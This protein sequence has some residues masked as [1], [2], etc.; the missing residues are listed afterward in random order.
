MIAEFVD[1]LAAAGLELTYDQIL[2]VLWLAGNLPKVQW[3][4]LH[5]TN[6]EQL[7]QA[8]AEFPP[9]LE[10]GKIKSAQ[11]L[12][13]PHLISPLAHDSKAESE[14]SRVSPVPGELYVPRATPD[15][16]G[17]IR[18]V[19]VRVPAAEA[20]PNKHGLNTA[21]RPLKRRYPSQRNQVLDVTATVEQIANGGPAVPILRPAPER[22]L[23]A[24][25]VIDESAS[26]K[27]WRDTI[28]EFETLLVRHGSFR[29][30]RP[31][32]VNLDDGKLKL[33]SEAGLPNDPRRLRHPRELI[34]PTARRLILIVSDCVAEGW[35]NQA[36][37]RAVL[38]WGQR[39]PVVLVQV[40]PERLWQATA[41]GDVTVLYRAHAAASPNV[42]LETQS[43]VFDLLRELDGSTI[44]ENI[45]EIAFSQLVENAKRA[46]DA[47]EWTMP[48]PVVNLEGWSV[49]PWAKLV[50]NLGDATAE[51]ITMRIPRQILPAADPAEG[52]KTPDPIET[53]PK[54]RIDRFR[55]AASPGARL[56]AGYLAV[57]PLCLPI[58]RLVQ[59]AMMSSVRQID[60]AEVLL[61]GLLE[62]DGSSKQVGQAEDIF[63]RFHPGVRELLLDSVTE[64]DKKRVLRAVSRL[65]GEMTGTTIN[66]RALLAGDPT[67]LEHSR[68]YPLGEKFAEVAEVV[69]RRLPHEDW[70]DTK[71]PVWSAAIRVYVAFASTDYESAK[72]VVKELD[73]FDWHGV[74]EFWSAID[75]RPRDM[76]AEMFRHRLDTASVFVPLL[77]QSYLES[78]WARNEVSVAIERK[79]PIFALPLEPTRLGDHLL[80]RYAQVADPLPLSSTED[81]RQAIVRFAETLAREF[82]KLNLAWVH[83]SV[84]SVRIGEV[85]ACGFFAGTNG[86]IVSFNANQTAKTAEIRLWNG[87]SLP[88]E[89]RASEP[90]LGLSL[91]VPSKLSESPTPLDFAALENALPTEVVVITPNG[92]RWGGS[93]KTLDPEFAITTE[94]ALRP[95]I[96]GCPVVDAAG[97]VL[98]I[99]NSSNISSG[100]YLCIRADRVQD[101]INAPAPQPSPI[102]PTASPVS[103]PRPRVLVVGTG[104]YELS[105]RV[106]NAARTVGTSVAVAGGTLITGGWSGVDYLAAEA[107]V[108]RTPQDANRL[109]N[110]MEDQNAPQ[111]A[112]GRTIRVARNDGIAESVR[113]ADLV[114]LIGGAGGTWQAFRE[115]LRT[116]R[117]V[118]PLLN[119]G[120]DAYHA[121]LLLEL[122]GQNVPTDIVRIAFSDRAEPQSESKR[123]SDL[124]RYWPAISGM[125]MPN[126][127]LLWMTEEVLPIA[128]RYMR[129]LGHDHELEAQRLLQQLRS[130][131]LSDTTRVRLVNAFA[132]DPIPEW[133]CIAYVAIQGRPVRD[134]EGVL[135]RSL[136]IEYRLGERERETRPLWRWLSAIR[137]VLNA[138]GNNLPQDLYQR[139][140]AVRE[141]LAR[142]R[143]VD[144]GGECKRLLSSILDGLGKTEASSKAPAETTADEESSEMVEEPAAENIASP[145]PTETVAKK[146]SKKALKKSVAKK[147]P[148]EAVKKATKK[149]SA[150]KT[151]KKA[152]KKAVKKAPKKK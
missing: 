130:Q 65:V 103:D 105:M 98:G 110:V 4:V 67:A 140:Q 87:I 122:F 31:W 58:M 73:R 54:T 120:T 14:S 45:E 53:A 146:A 79:M 47:R 138:F 123:L 37:F 18:A 129:K 118:L 124:F 97:R 17:T 126:G 35:R 9:S 115:A 135:A 74:A 55:E 38:E 96:A 12:S 40:L 145:A 41:L 108:Q 28:R 142:L 39:G 2:D 133:R 91:L 112:R 63:Y 144:P 61:S 8:T 60:L 66:F 117:P 48:L 26:M 121:A 100:E 95:G 114:V 23:E 141:G 152:A 62:Q 128:E 15:A 83:E 13:P 50:A 136:E 86:L 99:L 150:K 10:A 90:E 30:V 107:F 75:L 131:R 119:T 33:Y 132:V 64:G 116:G 43:S 27:V 106:Q 59:K 137:A 92:D 24:A 3:S 7:K 82:R 72:R 76:S 1:V 49:A 46:S 44:D 29:D 34:D 51:G 94:T 134:I 104:T 113:R 149:A 148:A 80:S 127:A 147:T 151:A 57:A 77:S 19:P 102:Q 85:I 6:A 139:I 93:A 11:P 42:R 69:A 71:D 143:D 84:V 78:E 109:L 32:Y 22:W 5:E 111:F 125:T 56:L 70:G 16:A 88:A 81:E 101:F 89:V 36:M 68:E 25:L 52:K 21:L 20:L